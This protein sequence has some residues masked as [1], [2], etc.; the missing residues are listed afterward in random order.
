MKGTEADRREG[1]GAMSLTGLRSARGLMIKLMAFFVAAAFLALS[2]SCS[3]ISGASLTVAGSTSVQP[4]A[5]LLAE[6]YMASHP[7]VS[8]NVQGGGSS[9]GIQA[10]LDGAA[11]IGMSSRDLKPEEQELAR[12][13]IA[14]DAI[15]II[16]HRSNPVTSLATGQ[17]RAI[18]SGAATDWSAIGGPPRRITVISREEGS[19]TR[20]AFQDLVMGET[21]VA[22]RALVQDSN[23]AIREV[24]ARDPWAIG[25]ISLGVIDDRV[26]AVA[27]DGTVPTV[28]S[29]RDKQYHL[30][31]PFLF[32]TRTEPTGLARE[33]ID[34]VLGPQGQRLLAQ[35]GLVWVNPWQPESE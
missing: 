7:D 30:V 9:A 18:F 17:V 26:R 19:G 22:P 11:D 6:S 32:L 21:E 20:S 27:L 25:Y 29:A 35:E 31:R 33:F 28:A 15:A 16:V 23:G 2:T 34:Y 13:C 8:I 12:H 5:E 24:V 4:F 1:A 14:Y 10:A 3:R